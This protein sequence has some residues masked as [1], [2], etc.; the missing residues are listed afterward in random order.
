VPFISQSSI[1]E[2]NDR[3]D[4]VAVLGDYVHLEKKGGRFWACCPF[5]QEKTASF[6]VNPDLKTYYC[7]GCHKGGTVINFIM[8]LDKLSFPEAI[9]LLAKRV[10]L[11]LVYEKSGEKGF[12]PEDEAKKK[13]KEE[14]FELYRRISGTFHHFLLKKPEAEEIKHYINNRG[15]NTDMVE[16]F[17]LGYSPADRYWLHNFL[18]RKGY[19]G[20]FLS[21]SGLFSSRHKKASLFAGRLIFPISDRQGRPVAFGGRLIAGKSHDGREL[22]KYI[23]SPELGIYKKGE[24]LYAVDIALPEIRKTKTVYI[25]EGYLDVIALHQAGISNTVAPLGTA[26][27]DEQAKLLKRWAQKVIF[28]FD[29][30]E[31]GHAAVI[32]GI[33]TSRK[34]GLDCGV[35]VHEEKDPADIL[36]VYGPEAAPPKDP[37][38]ILKIFGPE[39]LQ[40][41]AG[42]FINDLEYLL[43]R[44]RSLFDVSNSGEFSVQQKAQGVAFLFPYME[45]LD[46]EV[47]RGSCI[48]IAA[49]TFGL[50]P[51]L[52]A[53]DYRRYVEGNRTPDMQRRSASNYG[54]ERNGETVS[55]IRINDELS[56]LIAV[57]VNFASSRGE[58]LFP[59]FRAA[60]QINE[61]EDK[62]AKELFVALEECIRNGETGMDDL[63]ARISS[64]ELKK[65][66]VERSASGE[67]S[68][69]SEQ[70]V[71]DGIKKIKEKRL[72][73]SQEEI[74]IK[75]RSLKK[76]SGTGPEISGS[77]LYEE[78]NTEE[79]ELL[80]E[81]MRIDN[82]LHKLRRTR[83]KGSPLQGRRT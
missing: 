18:S 2:L 48:E 17:G 77:S 73:R 22:P 10:G 47:A 7:F 27:T 54:T 51:A 31:A 13:A 32:K 36:K 30:D 60:L 55:P 39:A 63:L 68:V 38:D 82:D 37:A 25:A 78:R 71:S 11:E 46:S 52:V 53:E 62:N 79:K 67:F 59:K 61:I 19:S 45:L 29:S 28:F 12:T 81:K 6:T 3:L 44:A 21:S 23:N 42:S 1:Q 35:V 64:P 8:E 76:N 83:S 69:N 56:L 57:A 43:I 15:I 41:R 5:H 14:L 74:I 4:A 26:F 49:D 34:N 24:T 75:L 9:E 50:L 20:E 72:E 40:K 16:R 65:N 80:A 66:V 58:T 33:Y 70:L